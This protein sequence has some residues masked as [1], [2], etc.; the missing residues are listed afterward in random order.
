MSARFYEATGL[1][2]IFNFIGRF[3]AASGL[4]MDNIPAS[5]D[6]P[7]ARPDGRLGGLAVNV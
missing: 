1:V 4:P 3:E 7:E 6:F 5:A 2:G